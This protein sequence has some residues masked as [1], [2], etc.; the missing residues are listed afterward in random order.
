MFFFVCDGFPYLF[1]LTELIVYHTFCII[2][3]VMTI[4][5]H[6][7]YLMH[8]EYLYGIILLL[9]RVEIKALL[10]SLLYRNL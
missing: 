8:G 4:S 2:I 7:I 1:D 5:E 3:H 9:L 6:Q 10:W